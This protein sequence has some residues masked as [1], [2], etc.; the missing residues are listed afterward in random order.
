MLKQV[1]LGRFEPVVTRFGPC[2][3]QNALKMGRFWTNNGSKKGA[4]CAFPKVTLD[5]LGFSN[6]WFY[7]V[8]SPWERVLAPENTKLP[9]KRAVSHQQCFKNGS[10]KLVY[11]SDTGPFGMLKQVFFTF[12]NP[13]VGRFGSWKIPTCLENGPF[14]TKNGSIMVKTALSKK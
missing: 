12:F 2:K 4:K 11:N 6:K 5:H 13:V 14:G 9:S 10:E 3:P 1:F 8:L 7:L